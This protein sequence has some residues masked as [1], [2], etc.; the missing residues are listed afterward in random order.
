MYFS[1][2]FPCHQIFGDLFISVHTD[3]LHSEYLFHSWMN[4]EINIPSEVRQRKTYVIPLIC[5]I[6][7]MIQ[8]NL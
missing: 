1:E 8:R 3:L 7:K 4:L 5:G 6:Q 2:N